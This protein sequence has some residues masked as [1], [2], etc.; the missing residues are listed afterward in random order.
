M[1]IN[2]SFLITLFPLFLLMHVPY[3]TPTAA[4]K[5]FSMFKIKYSEE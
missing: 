5:I 3:V 4:N 2:L 1:Y